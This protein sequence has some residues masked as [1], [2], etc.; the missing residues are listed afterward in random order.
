MPSTLYHIKRQICLNIRKELV[1]WIEAFISDRRTA[2]NNKNSNWHNIISGMPQA[3]FSV[4]YINDLSNLIKSSTFLF[5]DDIKIF[6]PIMDM[7][8]H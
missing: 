3:S 8:D 2:V 5:A 1:N 6:R 4:I 7:D